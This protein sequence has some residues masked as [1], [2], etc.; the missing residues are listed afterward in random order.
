MTQCKTLETRIDQKSL[1]LQVDQTEEIESEL[2]GLRNQHR[3]HMN[4][5]EKLLKEQK[6]RKEVYEAHRLTFDTQHKQMIELKEEFLEE[7]EVLVAKL[8]AVYDLYTGREKPVRHHKNK[9]IEFHLLWL[10]ILQVPAAE[11]GITLCVYRCASSICVHI[12]LYIQCI[13]IYIPY[14]QFQ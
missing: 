2:E 1:S 10:L 14:L 5:I 13:Y 8:E 9:V 7:R 12:L 4:V 3:R 11:N 6:E